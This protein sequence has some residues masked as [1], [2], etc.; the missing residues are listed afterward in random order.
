MNGAF[1]LVV[2]ACAALAGALVGPARAD[3]Q[4]KATPVAT[5]LAYP[6]F[7]TSAPGDRS[8]LYIIEQRGK[9]KVV[10]V[11]STGTYSVRPTPMVDLTSQLSSTYLEYGV[12]GLAFHPNFASNGYFYV[13]YT[14]GASPCDYAILRFKVSAADPNV[15]DMT[16]QTTIMRFSY[17]IVQ[18][19]AGWIGFGPDGY[20]YATT[21]DGGENDPNNAGSDLT[22]PKGKVLRIDVNGPDGVPGTT[23]DDGFPA[24][25]L[26]NYRIPA[27]NPFVATAGAAPEIWAYGLRNPWRS[28]F[29]R[30]TGDLWIGDVGQNLYEEVDFQPAGQGGAFYGWRCMEGFHVTTLAGCTGTLPSSTPPL[31]EYPHTGTGVAVGTSVTGGYVYRGCAMPS[32]RGTYFFGDWGGKIWTGTRSGSTLTGVVNRTAELAAPGTMVSFGEDALG[33]LYFVN[34][35]STAG[36]VYKIEPRVIDG[37]DCNG[38]GKPDSCDIANGTS[39]DANNNGIPDE[40]EPP[41]RADFNHIGGLTIQDIFDFLNAWLAAAPG[42][43][44]DNSGTLAVADIFA[45]INAWFAGC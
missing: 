8:H 10:E 1:A 29:D 39:L 21:G 36:A 18:H 23:D 41:C 11:S 9:I 3:V 37:P 15:A 5:G 7:V 27:S 16:T 31:F 14:P 45:F 19:R 26:K 42:S 32:L 44:F 35:N 43:D 33:E 22:V 4:F 30:Q 25:A 17:N 40:C 34:W 12:L 28:S 20:L 6:L 2:G 13:T 38:N 24:D